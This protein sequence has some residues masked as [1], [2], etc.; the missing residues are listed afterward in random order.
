MNVE[1]DAG[2]RSSSGDMVTIIVNDQ[3]G[4]SRPIAVMASPQTGTEYR[5]DKPVQLSSQGSTDPDNDELTFTWSSSLDGEL[6]TT[7]NF[8]TEVFLSDGLHVITLTA[9]DPRGASDS[10]SRQI[11]VVLAS[12]SYDEESPLLTSLGPL[13][14]LLLITLVSVVTRRH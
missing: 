4:N 7:P 12:D 5:N 1:D 8:F 11:T 14:T 2:V 9:V 6:Y 13:A 3:A 10:I